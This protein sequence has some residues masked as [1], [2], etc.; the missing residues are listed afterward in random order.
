VFVH[1]SSFATIL[2][3]FLLNSFM[4]LL[5]HYLIPQVMDQHL[6]S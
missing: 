5:G 2:S 3:C 4:L 6:Y 1:G